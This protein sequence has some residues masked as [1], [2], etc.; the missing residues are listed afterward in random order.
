VDSII[1]PLQTRQ[2]ISEGIQAAN[3]NPEMKEFK[4]GVFQV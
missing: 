3:N 4:T 1:D 2:V